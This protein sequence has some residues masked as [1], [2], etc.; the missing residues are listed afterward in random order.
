MSLMK[1]IFPR[2]YDDSLTAKAAT[3]KGPISTARPLDNYGKIAYHITT[4]KS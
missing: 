4:I 3:A 1:W 2:N